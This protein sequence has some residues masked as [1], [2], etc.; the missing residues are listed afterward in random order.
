MTKIWSQFYTPRTKGELLKAILPTWKGRKTDLREMSVK[1]IR[2]IYH[3]MRQSKLE[4]LMQKPK[5]GSVLSGDKG[6]ALPPLWSDRFKPHKPFLEVMK[7]G[8]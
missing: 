4:E 5:G 1:R 7:D 3:R 2:A 6:K 8:K